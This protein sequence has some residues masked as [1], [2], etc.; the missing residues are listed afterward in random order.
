MPESISRT[1]P[2]QRGGARPRR[3]DIQ[4]LRAIAVIAVI[5][6]HVVG[7]PHGGFVGVDVFFVI[8]GFLITSLLLR[9]AETSGGGISLTRFYGRRVKRLLPA[10]ATT[11]VATSAAAWALMNANDLRETAGDAVFSALF[12]GN[13]RFAVQGAD[14]FQQGTLPS[15]FMHFW[16]LGV[17]EQFYLVWPWIV[18]VVAGLLARRARWVARRTRA[19][20]AAVIALTTIASFAWSAYETQ[21]APEIAYFSTFSRAWELGAGA[22]L[23][24]LPTFTVATG[25]RRA[26]AWV[27]LTGIVTS[28]VAVTGSS[29]L[30]PAPLA[31]LPVASTAL[32]IVAG[33]DPAYAGPRLL[34][35][36]PMTYLGDISYS[37]Y[38]W[39]LP[40]AVMLVYALPAGSASYTVVALLVTVALAITC[41]RF[42]ESPMRDVSW[43]W[44]KDESRIASMRVCAILLVTVAAGASGQLAVASARPDMSNH[45]SIGAVRVLDGVAEAAPSDPAACWGATMAFYPEQCSEADL[46]VPRPTPWAFAE[47]RG[48]AFDCFIN[49]D[50][51]FRSCSYGV[52]SSSAYRVA[53]VGD[54]H[55]A[56]L[57]PALT[58]QLDAIGWRVDTFVGRGCVLA[59]VH[60]GT[61]NCAG[62]RPEINARLTSGDYDLVIAS[63]SRQ[64]PAPASRGAV[65]QIM[66][67]IASSGANIVIVE[68]V[69]ALD[70]DAVACALR[71][72]T[73]AEDGCG[74]AREVALRSPDQ[75]AA[76]AAAEGHRVVE[77]R[78]VYCTDDFC[79]TI[80]GNIIAYRDGNGHTSA[81]WMRTLSPYLVQRI[82]VAAEALPSDL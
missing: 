59:A 76:A 44:V 12:V 54:S 25:M 8:S 58:P 11:I 17:E 24:F 19:V 45:P 78:D 63:E 51:P 64:N 68:D 30:W 14:Y 31:L 81:T 28:A 47:D 7:W 32:I 3:R 69:P 71:N 77:T 26:V 52:Q 79:P 56:S 43:S 65:R 73:R 72:G 36:R 80:I 22:L 21:T 5:A 15:P 55:A 33:S 62:P 67:D 9:E 2:G 34:V 40:V 4:G 61:D 13:W 48:N 70:I 18:L 1:T 53:L 27:G 37:L 82:A 74:T 35:T 60:D 39:H 49:R 46:G 10:A 41:F 50:R 42:V 16:S 57:L 20:T 23:A 75:L 66:R 38:L 6:D 29:A